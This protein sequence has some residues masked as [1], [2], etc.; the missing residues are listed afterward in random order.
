MRTKKVILVCVVL[1]IVTFH[2]VF[3]VQQG[4]A[5][6]TAEHFSKIKDAKIIGMFESMNLDYQDLDKVKSAVEAVDYQAAESC[7][8]RALPYS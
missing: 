2:Q 3:A 5:R 1:C 4:F 8:P 7:L 6:N